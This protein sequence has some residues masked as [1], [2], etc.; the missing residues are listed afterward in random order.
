MPSP[1][2]TYPSLRDRI[3]LIT[4]GGS[5][6]G[7]SLVEHF[8]E[9]G[10]RVA[11]LDRDLAASTALVAS[12]STSTY[13]PVFLPCDVTDLAALQAAIDRVLTDLGPIHT[14]INNAGRDARHHFAEVTPEFWEDSLATNLRH[15]FFAAQAVTPVM[16]AARTGSI[17]NMSSIGWLIPTPNVPVYH[18]AKAA[19]VGITHALAHEL[20]PDNIRVNAILPGAILTERQRRDVWTPEYE[21]E[22]FSRQAIKRSLVAADVARLCLFLAAD[23]SSAITNQTHIIDGGWI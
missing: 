1:F 13:P 18:A 10:S 3:V 8:A 19:L 4:G 14:L 5:G 17:L 22:I 23:D 16:R 21:A 6:I 12:L 9:Q 2:A 11:F 20:G 7:A 15:A